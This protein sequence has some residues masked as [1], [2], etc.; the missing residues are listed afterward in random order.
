VQPPV[1]APEAETCKAP[2]VGKVAAKA[3]VKHLAAVA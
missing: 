1:L 2:P 3:E